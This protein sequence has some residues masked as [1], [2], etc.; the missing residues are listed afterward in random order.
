MT[1]MQFPAARRAWLKLLEAARASAGAAGDD[2]L[3]VAVKRAMAGQDDTTFPLD[4]ADERLRAVKIFVAWLRFWTMARAGTRT[5][6][7]SGL[8]AM[9][10]DL[11]RILID[12][13][14][15]EAQAHMQRQGLG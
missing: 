9:A 7:A 3:A 15:A 14:A 8:A 6:F 10:G 1:A 12:Q 13:G 2:G 5:A 4:G 11:E